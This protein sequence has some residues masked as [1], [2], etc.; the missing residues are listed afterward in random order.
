[1]GRDITQCHPKL[2]IL[3]KK[4]I[5]ECANHG[6]KI[7]I[8]ECFRS[9]EEQDALYAIGRTKG[10]AEAIVTKAKGSSYSSMHQWG[11]AFDIYRN[12]GRGNY[13]ESD[14]F[15]TKVGKIGSTS[16]SNGAEIGKASRTS[17]TSNFQIGEVHQAN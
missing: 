9:V 6:L 4:L 8:G 15:F 14:D 17:L 11:V 3:A 12:D 7:A 5:H 1:L 10:R 16:V 2:Q 13:N